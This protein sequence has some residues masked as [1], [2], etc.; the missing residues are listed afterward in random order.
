MTGAVAAA[1]G[2]LVGSPAAAADDEVVRD[3]VVW[4]APASCP[5]SSEIDAKIEAQIGTLPDDAP[6][7]DAAV[8]GD[9]GEYRMRVR[10]VDGEGSTSRTLEAADCATLA[11]AFVLLVAV[12]VGRPADTSPTEPTRSEPSPSTGA[13]PRGRG[14]LG[15]AGVVEAG[16]LPAWSGGAN[17]H[18]AWTWPRWVV[19]AMVTYIGPRGQTIG[20]GAT[21]TVQRYAVGAFGGPVLRRRRFDLGFALGI[22]AGGAIASSRGP[23]GVEQPHAPLVAGR[24]EVR[25]AVH[26]SRRVSLTASAAGLLA[27]TRLRYRHETERTLLASTGAGAIAGTLGIAFRFGET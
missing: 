25:F 2:L 11:D 21:L 3:G 10:L 15:V 18:G 4:R 24:S 6:R 13:R 17:V 22:E 8:I 12:A 20:P 26:V 9:E 7:A 23:A 16:L 19:G 14:E 5:G 1:L 27:F